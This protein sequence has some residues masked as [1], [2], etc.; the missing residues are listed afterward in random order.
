LDLGEAGIDKEAGG[1]FM[2]NM[3][4]T[5]VSIYLNFVICYV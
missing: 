5:A 2:M 1:K 4:S 3:V